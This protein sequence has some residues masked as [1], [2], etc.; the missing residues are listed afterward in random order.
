M[1]SA[2]GAMRASIRAV[3]LAC[4]GM[5]ED[6]P[7]EHCTGVCLTVQLSHKRCSSGTATAAALAEV[8]PPQPPQSP[9][10]AAAAPRGHP[11]TQG[12]EELLGFR[13]LRRGQAGP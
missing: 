11:Y 13:G 5:A 3:R 6:T 12:P 2:S 8:G 4:W 7:K 9:Q 1:R 10:P